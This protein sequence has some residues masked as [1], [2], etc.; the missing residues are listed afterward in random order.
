MATY[1]CDLCVYI[2]L[3]VKHGFNPHAQ[4]DTVF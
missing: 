1:V 3:L 4:T 2:V